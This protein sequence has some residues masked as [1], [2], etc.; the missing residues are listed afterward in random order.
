MELSEMHEFSI[1]LRSNSINR[2]KTEQFCLVNENI[3][4]D[5]DGLCLLCFTCYILVDFFWCIF[6][7][8]SLK[9]H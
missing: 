6:V 7:L 4:H 8:F 5:N 1:N 9:G 2:L 3:T